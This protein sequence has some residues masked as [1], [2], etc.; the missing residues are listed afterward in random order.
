MICFYFKKRE[1]T[2]ETQIKEFPRKTGSVPILLH[3]GRD[4][5]YIISN[6]TISPIHNT[7]IHTYMHAHRLNVFI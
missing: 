3:T 5:F 1:K 6:N 7:H 2:S 4:Y